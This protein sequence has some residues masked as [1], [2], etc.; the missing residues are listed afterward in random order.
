MLHKNVLQQNNWYRILPNKRSQHCKVLPECYRMYTVRRDRQDLPWYEDSRGA[1]I[2]VLIKNDIIGIYQ[3]STETDC[4]I[5][6]VKFDIVG[7]KQYM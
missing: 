1:G 2:F 7:T 6:R 4:E 5:V 3:V